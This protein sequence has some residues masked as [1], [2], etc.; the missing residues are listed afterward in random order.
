MISIATSPLLLKG[1][2]VIL[3]KRL[4][5]TDGKED[6]I[7]SIS[8]GADR[9]S[10][11]KVH[12]LSQLF[13][14]FRDLVITH[15]SQLRDIAKTDWTKIPEHI[16]IDIKLVEQVDRTSTFFRYPDPMSPT[17]DKVKSGMQE[18]NPEIRPPKPT[19][20]L[21]VDSPHGNKMY[22][23][24][25]QPMNDV[26]Q[27]LFRLAETLAGAALGLRHEIGENRLR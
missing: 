6:S 5:L 2:I 18:R 23:L 20:S 19:I 16:E 8:K 17:G 11:K 21:F 12:S 1:A 26:V 10:F 7:C 27:A 24:D 9:I 14:H 22:S 3:N 4:N 15:Q 25:H 13:E